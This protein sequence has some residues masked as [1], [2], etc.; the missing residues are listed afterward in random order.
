MKEG[1]LTITFDE[2]DVGDLN[3]RKRSRVTDVWIL[4]Q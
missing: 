1:K 4:R 3:W 2:P